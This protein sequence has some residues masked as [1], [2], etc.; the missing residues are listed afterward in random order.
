V[1]VQDQIAA[2]GV[3]RTIVP[4]AF[5]P[6]FSASRGIVPSCLGANKRVIHSFEKLVGQRV[7]LGVCPRIAV[8]KIRKND[9][10]CAGVVQV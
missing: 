6:D 4:T 9:P 7:D 10:T 5:V 1:T 2:V 8:W 3:E